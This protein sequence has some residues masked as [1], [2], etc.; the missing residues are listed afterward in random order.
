M[1]V[2]FHHHVQSTFE[3]PRYGYLSSKRDADTE[4]FAK[5]IT[6]SLY[7]EIFAAGTGVYARRGKPYGTFDRF[8]E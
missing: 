6:L 1:G 7:T 8:M 2:F 4:A 5:G 3:N